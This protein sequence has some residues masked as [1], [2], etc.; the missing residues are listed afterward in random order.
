MSKWIMII[1][2]GIVSCGA[3]ACVSLSREHQEAQN[4]EIYNIDFGNLQDGTYRGIYEGG[5][6][7]W[8]ASEVQ[9]TVFS[10]NVTAIELLKN[11]ED[12]PPEF[13]NELFKG[14]IEQQ[15]LQVDAISGATLTSK[16][17]LKAVEN[18]LIKAE[19]K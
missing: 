10:G 11:T 17:Y 7:K 16:A 1:M 14:V 15:S 8:R 13:T 6:Y 19:R 5:M 18:A 9:V 12:R 3:V 2:V 4:L